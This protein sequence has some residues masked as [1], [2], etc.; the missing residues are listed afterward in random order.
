M[1]FVQRFFR[2]VLLK[3]AS[4]QWVYTQKGTWLIVPGDPGSY[5]TWIWLFL[6]SAGTVLFFAGGVFTRFGW[7]RTACN[8]GLSVLDIVYFTAWLETLS[9]LFSF[10]L[11]LWPEATRHLLPHLPFLWM[12]GLM[13]LIFWRRWEEIGFV[14]VSSPSWLVWLLAVIGVYILVFLFLDQV[15]TRPVA[16]WFSLEL[17]SWRGNLIS[18][19]LHYTDAAG[20]L[21][22][23]SQWL[24]IGL[25]GPVAEEIFFRGLIQSWISKTCGNGLAIFLSAASFS[26]FHMD[27]TM[28]APLFVLGLILAF[29]RFWT[30][31]LWA[32]VAFHVLNNFV[33]L[34][35]EYL[36]HS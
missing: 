29:F 8:Q 11:P 26:L 20:V 4:Q 1:G 12:I 16:E 14:R 5:A 10:V 2:V 7:E 19:N 24:L 23:G 9:V 34:L 13:V 30:G 35:F 21:V 15:I 28:L 25:I 17:S 31:Q 18:K 32:P 3:F 36:P 33:A 27:I 22:S 6:T